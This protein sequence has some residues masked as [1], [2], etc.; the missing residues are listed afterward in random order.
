M[1][2]AA[3]TAVPG[4]GL[5]PRGNATRFTYIG[6]ATA[7]AQLYDADANEKVYISYI[8]LNPSEG[9]TWDLNV[10]DT[11]DGTVIRCEAS[12]T[13][14]NAIAPVVVIK[15]LLFQ[16]GGSATDSEND[17]NLTTDGDGTEQCHYVICGWIETEST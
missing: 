13:A 10:G 12:A 7:T 4:T 14:N 3:I 15:D 5:L 11:T 6:T 9:G 16:G 1:A 2:V 8:Y 17:I